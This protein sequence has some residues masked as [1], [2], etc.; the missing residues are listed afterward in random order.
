[1]I[2]KIEE[3]LS[4][5]RCPRTHTKLIMHNR[6]LISEGGEEYP[7]VNGKPILVKYLKP[8]H[9]T[10]PPEDKTSQNQTSYS[11]PAT[12]ISPSDR[13]LHLGSGNIPCA[14]HRV[15]SLDVLPCQHVDIVSEAEELPFQDNTFDYVESGAVFEHVYDPAEAIKEVKRVLKHDGIFRIDTAF[16]QSFHGFPEHYFNMT[17]LAV[18]TFLADDFIL[19]ESYVPDSATPL[20]SLIDLVERFISFLSNKDKQYFM[21]CSMEK[22][23]DMMKSDPSRKNVLLSNFSE[24]ALRSMAASFVVTAR[25]PAKYQETIDMIRRNRTTSDEWD[26]LKRDY[27]ASRMELMLRHHEIFFYKRLSLEKGAKP[28]ANIFDPEPLD[29]ILMRCKILNPLSIAQLKKSVEL[30]HREEKKL[31][32]IR[33]QWL[34]IYMRNLNLI[35]V[36][37]KSISVIKKAGFR[38][39][40]TKVRKKLKFI[41]AASNRFGKQSN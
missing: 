27:Y 17:P 30:L 28:P 36:A 13:I 6:K 11:A 19:E 5:L 35:D 34:Y 25:K 41:C 16:M 39:F 1:M 4:I 31:E 21:T 24:Y 9:L 22:A 23:M 20:K 38:S 12:Y 2:T 18:E 14:D 32:N 7:I 15:I 3:I 10:P 33:D 29:S 37:S 26:I 8:I 40:L